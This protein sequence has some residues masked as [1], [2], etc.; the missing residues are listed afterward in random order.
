MRLAAKLVAQDAP[1][2]RSFFSFLLE[3]M[4]G[5]LDGFLPSAPRGIYDAAMSF[6]ETI[7]LFL[8][9][10]VVFGPKKLPEIGR[11][12]G[13]LM[14]EFKRA[15][16]EFRSQVESEISQLEVKENR[17]VKP[18]WSKALQDRLMVPTKP[19]E[20]VVAIGSAEPPEAGKAHDV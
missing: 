12:I 20:G 9:A 6:G 17:A 13:K 19:P 5:M 11:Q 7:F 3:S 4:S 14:A 8:L 1:L 16:N 15:S 18:D 10:L 2:R